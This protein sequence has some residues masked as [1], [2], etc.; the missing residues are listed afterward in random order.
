ML[1]DFLNRLEKLEAKN[2]SA[3]VP[4]SH[5]QDPI[6]LK[7]EWTGYPKGGPRFRLNRVSP[8]RWEFRRTGYFVM[9]CAMFIA[10]G[11]GFF[12]IPAYHL[13]PSDVRDRESEFHG[14]HPHWRVFHHG[15]IADVG[16]H[17]GETDF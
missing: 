7:T 8:T 6:A 11:S 14:S 15:G 9:L 2:V 17:V 4:S 10:L 16:L 3:S 5:F 1:G 12:I 13:T